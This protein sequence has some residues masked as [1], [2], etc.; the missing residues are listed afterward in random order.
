MKKKKIIIIVTL[1]VVTITSFVLEFCFS[2]ELGLWWFLACF[3]GSTIFMVRTINFCMT[4]KF[5]PSF[6]KEETKGPS[7]SF[8]GYYLKKNNS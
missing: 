6:A 3:A 4:G 2:A 5:F 8:E 1:W 7:R